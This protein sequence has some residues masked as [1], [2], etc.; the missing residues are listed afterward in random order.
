MKKPLAVVGLVFGI[1]GTILD[2]FWWVTFTTHWNDLSFVINSTD[3]GNDI[4]LLMIS[5][6]VFGVISVFMVY[7]GCKNLK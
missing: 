6:V 3:G 5:F 4:T 2:I 7:S 1:I